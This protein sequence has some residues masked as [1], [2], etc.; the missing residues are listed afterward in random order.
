[1]V[2]KTDG[3]HLKSSDQISHQQWGQRDMLWLL[4]WCLLFLS[5]FIYFETERMS[6]G[7]AHREGERECQVVSRLSVQ[8][9]MWGSIPET[10]R[11]WPHDLNQE[12]DTQL[13][14]PPRSSGGDVLRRHNINIT[15][16]EFLPKIHGLHLIMS[17]QSDKPKLRDTL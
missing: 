5:L 12:L 14:E 1:M 4:K 7:E 2:E 13:T 9:P 3:C 11:S 10:V 16:V 6:R 17:K 8:S 15:H